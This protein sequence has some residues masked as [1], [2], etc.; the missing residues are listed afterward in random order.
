MDYLDLVEVVHSGTAEGAVASRKSSRLNEM[1]LNPEAGSKAERCAGILGDIGLEQGDSHN[2]RRVCH[3]A[4]AA[5]R[6]GIAQG[7]ST[8]GTNLPHGCISG[9]APCRQG[10]QSADATV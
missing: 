8:I 5:R 2:S 6:P 7:P 1:D 4:T 10:S 3:R 9:L